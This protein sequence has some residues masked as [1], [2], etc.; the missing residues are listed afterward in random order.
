LGFRGRRAIT[1]FLG[2]TDQI[3]EMILA[4][5]PSSELRKAAV[6]GGMTSLRAAGLEKV[7]NGE[8]T[9]KEVNR[10]TFSHG[11]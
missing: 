2:L 6:A 9:L 1:E 11:S 3:K 7:L 8:T 4:R 10:I 5:R